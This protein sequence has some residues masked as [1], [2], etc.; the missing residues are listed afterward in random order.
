M[1]QNVTI[2]IDREI[3]RRAKVLAAQ[4]ETSLSRLLADMLRRLVEEDEGYRRAMGRAV[5]ALGSGFHLGGRITATREELH[6]RSL[7]R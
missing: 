3:L 2:S 6:E 5:A 1:K 4:Q 7:L